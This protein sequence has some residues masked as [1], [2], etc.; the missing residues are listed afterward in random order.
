MHKPDALD[1]LPID[2]DFRQRGLDMTRI[3]TFTDAAFAFSLTLLVISFDAIPSSYEEM[4]HA[5]KLIP[6]FAACFAQISLFWYAHHRWSR[7]MGLDDKTTI[8]LSLALVFVTLVYVFPLR[9][10][11]SALF[12]LIS[13]N[14]LPFDFTHYTYEQIG[15]IFLIYGIGFIA[16]SA[17]IC[18]L[19]LHSL[20]RADALQLSELERYIVRCEIGVWFI[21]TLIG[22]L[23][24]LLAILLPGR[25][26]PLSGL[27]YA[28]FPI[29]MP[30]FDAAIR[31]QY[32]QIK[33]RQEPKP[34]SVNTN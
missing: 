33:S 17:V 31:K 9:I 26:S 16:M 27:A 24:C 1:T 15:S 7:C 22:L 8:V 12:S 18:L 23:S 32:Q 3:E 14:Y 6:S 2:G 19:Y 11:F 20:R 28:L 10:M 34:G 25:Y 4:I 21:S 5:L 30:I 29:A 13:N